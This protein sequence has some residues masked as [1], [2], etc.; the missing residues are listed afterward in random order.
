MAKGLR[1]ALSQATGK[2]DYVLADLEKKSITFRQGE[3]LAR[4]LLRAVE[5]AELDQAMRAGRRKL[6]RA[7]S[8]L[9][10]LAALA[11]LVL[12][13]VVLASPASAI[14]TVLGGILVICCLGA[15][16]AIWRTGSPLM[17]MWR[18]REQKRTG[19]RFVDTKP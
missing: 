7:V 16:L 2:E 10:V 19:V 6:V 18:A 15:L 13:G 1:A 14:L 9:V 11:A 4:A 8:V 3:E 17:N 12:A 5:G